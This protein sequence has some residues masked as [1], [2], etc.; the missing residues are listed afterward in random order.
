MT[1]TEMP[2]EPPK[3]DALLEIYFRWCHRYALD[4]GQDL[5]KLLLSKP[6]WNWFKVMIVFNEPSVVKALVRCNLT[7]WDYKILQDLH[8]GRVAYR[9][10][11]S[12]INEARKNHN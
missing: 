12:L 5:Q 6:I 2:F 4:S 7:E 1:T 8:E 3:G 10:P 9:Y 11:K